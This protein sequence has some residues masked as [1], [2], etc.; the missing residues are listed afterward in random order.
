[1]ARKRRTK[2]GVWIAAMLVAVAAA[3]GGYYYY[4]TQQ[5]GQAEP[6]QDMKTTKARRGD[7]IVST[8]GSGTVIPFAEVDLAF[9]DGGK[10]VELMVAPGDQVVTGQVLARIDDSDARKALV[11][12][13]LTLAR[14]ETSLSNVKD[15]L[16]ELLEDAATVDLLDAQA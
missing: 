8:T 12:A 5:V 13:Q 2:R 10:I 4:T 15:A 3:S 7:I 16:A 6:A 9:A 11:S 14:A 1:M